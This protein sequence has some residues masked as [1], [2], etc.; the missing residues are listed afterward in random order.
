VPDSYVANRVHCVFSTKSRARTIPA[1]MQPRLWSFMAGI[2]RENGI[3]PISIG[4]FDDHAHV[5]IGIPPTVALAKAMQL[6]KAGS[7][8]WCNQNFGRGRFE[9]QAGYSA[10]SVSTS[11]IEKTKAYI[12]NQREHHRKRDFGQEWRLFL[13]R[14]GFS[15]EEGLLL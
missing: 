7:S 1:E 2:A 8:K 5:L 9:W 10:A 14:N 3:I 12:R 6:I 11:M 4:G 15:V 13:R